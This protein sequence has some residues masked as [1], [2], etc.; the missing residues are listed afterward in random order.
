MKK[1]MVLMFAAILTLS[2]CADQATTNRVGA[3]VAGGGI[4]AVA[5][6]ALGADSGWTAVAAG[7]GAIAGTLYAR[8][9]QTGECAHHSGD[10]ETFHV[11]D[12]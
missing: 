4:A 10:G 8:N 12:C 6:T 7:A 2:A 5:A 11:S 3:G 1:T 9:Q